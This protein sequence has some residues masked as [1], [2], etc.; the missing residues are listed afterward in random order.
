MKK[1]FLSILAMAITLT[2]AAETPQLVFH[3]PADD[4]TGNILKNSVSTTESDAKI[5]GADFAWETDLSGKKAISFKNPVKSVVGKS[6]CAVAKINNKIDF[7]QP[8]TI[9][10]Y[11]YLDPVLPGNR[12]YTIMSTAKT[13]FGPGWRIIYN[14]GSLMFVGGVGKAEGGVVANINPSRNKQPKGVWHHLTALYDGENVKLYFNG[15][16]A[17]A[18]PMKLQN[19]HDRITIGAYVSGYNYGFAGSLADIKIFAGALSPEEIVTEVQG[20]TE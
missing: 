7:T 4:G 2:L 18:K 11:L 20:I 15:I 1:L 17:A 5:I 14:Y 3:F 8:F 10:L 12:Q 6:S 9:M 19:G 16:E 13:D